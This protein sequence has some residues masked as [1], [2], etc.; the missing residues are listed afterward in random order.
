[1]EFTL[2]PPEAHQIERQEGLRE[3]SAG[4]RELPASLQEPPT[5]P[6]GL[7]EGLREPPPAGPFRI[8]GRSSTSNYQVSGAD[9]QVVDVHGFK[10]QRY[11]E[12]LA[13]LLG[14]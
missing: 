2:V 10:L 3:L 1:M 8:V 6:R 11:A 5:A 4:S 7:Q 14:N 9:G 13:D 12:S